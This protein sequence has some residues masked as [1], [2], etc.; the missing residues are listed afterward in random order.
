MTSRELPP[1]SPFAEDT[2]EA[3][4][5]LTAAAGDPAAIVRAMGQARVLVPVVAQLE[6]V[7]ASEPVMGAARSSRG[8]VR[9][10]ASAG[11]DGLAG[12]RGVDTLGAQLA[13]AFTQPRKHASAA[14]V[15][16]AAPDGRSALP[17]FSSME[18]LQRWRADAR[19]I[20][21]EGRRAAAAAI[22]E[23]DALVI[24]DPGSPTEQLLVRPAV[25]AI[26][27]QTEWVGAPTH[28][29][30]RE[31][32]AQILGQIP[33]IDSHGLGAGRTAELRIT[34]QLI[35]GLSRASVHAATE[36]LS[37]ALAS[38]QVF[39]DHVDSVELSFQTSQPRS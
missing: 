19:P 5:H 38:S 39:A 7:P 32:V 21:V 14:M 2:G 28:P 20:P 37:A 30:V 26:V 23:A 33:H 4:P 22:Q 17:V 16:V 10:E 24:L 27:N 13:P 9:E 35:P 36:H 3:D 25:V 11:S 15:T 18:A 29:Q 6:D 31:V 12:D 1:P 34:V 8:E